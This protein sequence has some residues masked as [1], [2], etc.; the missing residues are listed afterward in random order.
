[1]ST[2]TTYEMQERTDGVWWNVSGAN[3]PSSADDARARLKLMRQGQ[4]DREVR[5][6]VITT[7]RTISVLEE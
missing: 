2:K 3:P 4:P 7:T 6:L 5:A 1:M